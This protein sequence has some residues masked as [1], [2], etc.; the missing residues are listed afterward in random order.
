[1]LHKLK[2]KWNEKTE[3]RERANM[4]LRTRI[5]NYGGGC[6]ISHWTEALHA[7]RPLRRVLFIAYA[8]RKITESP[9]LKVLFCLFE[10]EK[11]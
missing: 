3:R 7:L 9:D 6:A 4:S 1:M 10:F 2:C 11:D 5:L 8:R